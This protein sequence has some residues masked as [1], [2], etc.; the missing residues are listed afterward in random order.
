MREGRGRRKIIWKGKRRERVCGNPNLLG[1]QVVPAGF[2]HTEGM[3][4]EVRTLRHLQNKTSKVK[5][6]GERKCNCPKRE[7]LVRL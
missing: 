6:S 3:G 7:M 5:Q 2:E 4:V 1:G